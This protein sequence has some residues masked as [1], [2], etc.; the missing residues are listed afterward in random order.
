MAENGPVEPDD[1]VHDDL[2]APAEVR[3]D[4]DALRIKQIAK[5][6]RAAYRS[7][8]YLLIASVLCAA[9]AGQMIW[10]GIGRYRNEARVLG[11]G[12]VLAALIVLALG[13]RAF[14]RARELKAEADKSVLEEPRT[15]PDFSK[16]SDG[17]QAWKNL[18]DVE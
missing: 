15:P 4:L 6:R 5:L 2:P 1:F 13:W 7:R 10:M 3:D 16:L 18:E 12:L 9:L 11:A 14:G 8:G 17:S